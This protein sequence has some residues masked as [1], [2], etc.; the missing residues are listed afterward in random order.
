M[1]LRLQIVLFVLLGVSAIGCGNSDR[2][3]LANASGKVTLDGQPV[4]QATVTFYPVAGGRPSAAITDSQGQYTMNSFDD[5]RGA[6]VGDHNVSVMKI[7][8]Q[9]A[10]SP[11][12]ADDPVA[13]GGD[14]SATGD[15][16]L[17][18]AIGEADGQRAE[19][20]SDQLNYV[21]PAKYMDATTSGL[22]ISVPA[23]GSASLDIVL[24][25]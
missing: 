23:S 18:P 24:Q 14:E 15:N 8:G 2:P 16:S 22:K 21:V 19:N 12:Q 9:G 20:T 10:W 1:S 25:Q 7:D 11:E 3:A 6:I 5:A 13:G 4:A 17:S